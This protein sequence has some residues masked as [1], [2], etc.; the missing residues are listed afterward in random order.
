MRLF[1]IHESNS[2]SFGSGNSDRLAYLDRVSKATVRRT[3]KGEYTASMTIAYT[4]ENQQLIQNDRIIRLPVNPRDNAP[5]QAFRIHSFDVQYGSE[6]AI[7]VEL[8]HVS[9]DMNYMPVIS[10]AKVNGASNA[11]AA[12]PGAVVGGLSP[13][14]ITTNLSDISTAFE[15]KKIRSLR[16]LIGDGEDSIMALFKAECDFNNFQ[17]SIVSQ[18]GLEKNLELVLFR[19]MVDCS[20]AYDYNDFRT[21]IFPYWTDS[22]GN[23]RWIPSSSGIER[24]IPT[25]SNTFKHAKYGILDLSDKFEKQPTYQQL[26]DKTVEEIAKQSWGSP[27]L[28]IN[29][30][31]FV[32]FDRDNTGN[33]Y[34][35]K[36]ADLK[37]GDRFD[38]VNPYTHET[39]RVRLV[40]YEY[41]CLEDA[42]TSMTIDTE[43]AK[44]S[45]TVASLGAVVSGLV[46]SSIVSR[47]WTSVSIA[48][49]GS[50]YLNGTLS[51]DSKLEVNQA[52]GLARIHGKFT[53]GAGLS[54]T[55]GTYRLGEINVAYVPEV[56][57]P[58]EMW[59]ATGLNDMNV[60]NGSGSNT[61]GYNAVKGVIHKLSGGDK[62]ALSVYNYSGKTIPSGASIYFNGMWPYY[63]K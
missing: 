25:S 39:K 27:K 43:Y 50:G 62:A 36:Q 56:P 7:N 10:I 58:I 13:F 33:L 19:N 11:V 14:T 20:E 46:E 49:G 63:S 2:T 8:D 60:G 22:D 23:S 53:L 35:W 32:P 40:E 42:Y 61:T 45:D 55:Y 9:Y 28:T 34:D 15:S 57:T 24:L 6:K 41:D 47:N 1:P 12:I 16:S 5:V 52:F 21:A 54:G 29:L 30:N 48:T 37:I 51:A 31:A 3:V 38:Y 17:V 18:I 44:A 4:P 26:H 59:V